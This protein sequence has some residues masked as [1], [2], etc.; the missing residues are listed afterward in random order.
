MSKDYKYLIQLV[1]KET[2][3]F[4]NFRIDAGIVSL[5]YTII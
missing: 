2:F 3:T 5:K 4:L 1:Y